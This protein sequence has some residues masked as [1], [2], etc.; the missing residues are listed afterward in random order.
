MSVTPP[1]EEL[2]LSGS[3]TFPGFKSRDYHIKHEVLVYQHRR[4]IGT[5]QG[6]IRPGDIDD[7]PGWTVSLWDRA[8]E[9]NSSIWSLKRL[10]DGAEFSIGDEVDVASAI[11]VNG[12][13]ENIRVSIGKIKKFRIVRGR[14]K[15]ECGKKQAFLT[16]IELKRTWYITA[17][18]KITFMLGTVK[19]SAPTF[20]T[21]EEAQRHLIENTPCFTLS[22]VLAV[23][24]RT[25]K[26]P[27]GRELQKL[28][29]KKLKIFDIKHKRY[30]TNTLTPER[31]KE[32]AKKAALAR[33]SGEANQL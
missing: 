11:S 23:T 21:R 27:Y 25:A 31:R 16:E 14:M 12:K 9:N 19:L 28:A 22:E 1:V 7:T 15:V 13:A 32:I 26:G 6:L 2:S 33:W 18:S 17:K 4:L 20:S 5:N 24:G 29:K 30:K 3:D 8:V 10:V